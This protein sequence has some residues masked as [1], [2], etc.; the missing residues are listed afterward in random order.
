M[1][2]VLDAN[3]VIAAFAARGLCEAVFELCLNSHN[4]IMSEHLLFEI[5]KSL[6]KKI[7]LPDKSTNE[8]IALLRDNCRIMDP[9]ELPSTVCRDPNDVPV[10]GLAIQAKADYIITGDK[11]LLVLKEFRSI[12]ILSPRDFSKKLNDQ[13]NNIRADK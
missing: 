4:I 3:V 8:I 9:V 11:D 10:L 13:Q 1:K 5:H 6:I 12:P 2:I 7:K